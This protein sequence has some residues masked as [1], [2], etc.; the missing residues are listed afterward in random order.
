MFIAIAMLAVNS[1][2]ASDDPS[3]RG[4]KQF[5][6]VIDKTTKAAEELDRSQIKVDVEL[7]LR[8]AGIQVTDERPGLA[9]LLVD[10]QALISRDHPDLCVFNI[11]L[12][13]NQIVNLPVN[14]FTMFA[15][16]WHDSSFG[17]VIEGNYRKHS[18]SH[19]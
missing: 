7:R 1:T 5:Y 10:P 17:Y 19:R 3:L 16:T 14:G 13:F 15:P 2:F 18:G 11:D 6:V 9:Y 12:D 4:V 8:K